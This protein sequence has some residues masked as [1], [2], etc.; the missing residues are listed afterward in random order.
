M[1]QVLVVFQFKVVNMQQIVIIID[2]IYVVGVFYVIISKIIRIVRVG[3]RMRDWR[4]FL[5]VRFNNVGFIVGEGFYF[6]ICGDFMGVDYSIL[7]FLCRE[8]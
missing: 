6:I 1:L 4:V 7:I 5:K 3:K 8:K 2:V